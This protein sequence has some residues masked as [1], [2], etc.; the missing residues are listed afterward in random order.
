MKKKIILGSLITIFIIAIPLSIYGVKQYYMVKDHV[1]DM[2][3]TIDD[4]QNNN[5]DN[6]ED[7]DDELTDRPINIH[8]EPLTYLLLGIGNRPDDPGRADVIM[9]VSINPDKEE[10]LTF[11]IPRDTKTE[12]SG[13]N[14]YDKINHAY[15][16]GGTKTTK[17]TVEDFIDSEIDDVVQINM[18]GFRDLVDAIGGVTVDNSFSFEQA[19]ELGK[20]TY[21]YDKGEIDLDGEEALHYS[22]MRKQDP[23]GDLGRN[24]RQ[25]Q[26]IEAILEKAKSPSAVFSLNDTMQAL[27]SNV[28]TTIRFSEIKDLFKEYQ[29]DWKD[30]ELKEETLDVEDEWAPEGF[31]FRITDEEQYRVQQELA[32]FL[33]KE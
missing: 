33:E 25:K 6:N 28:K 10:I 15:S 19:D 18:Q 9:V 3:I 8:D 32:D 26:V 23:E 14:S 31:Y 30:F 12:I 16:Y 7:I 2:H 4:E 29:S 24:K 22:R 5:S 21:H 11:N 13:K 27:S 17:E 1:D 20:E